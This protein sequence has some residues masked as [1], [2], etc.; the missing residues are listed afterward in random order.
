MW[1]LHVRTVSTKVV[2]SQSAKP[3][4]THVL[5][6][7]I[8]IYIYI[9]I[10]YMLYSVTCARMLVLLDLEHNA[11]RKYKLCLKHLFSQTKVLMHSN[12]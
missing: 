7:Y 2:I 9:Y 6:V 11:R 3:K 10:W 5:T 12:I 8:Y 1:P 4:I